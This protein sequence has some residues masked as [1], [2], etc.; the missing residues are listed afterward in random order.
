MIIGVRADA[1]PCRLTGFP[2]VMFLAGD[3][4]IPFAYVFGK[5]QYV[6]HRRPQPVTLGPG[7]VAYFL[8]AKYRCDR[9]VTET[10]DGMT[11]MLPGQGT[12]VTPPRSWLALS[13][14]YCAGG[15]N[16]P[17][18]TVEVSPF[19]PDVPSLAT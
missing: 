19:E 2:T 11:V 17:G 3:V 13:I 4:P 9:G 1:A 16:D 5:G 18:N 12:V 15:A 10:A 14:D 6:T 8:V 7:K